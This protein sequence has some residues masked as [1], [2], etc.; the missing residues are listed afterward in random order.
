MYRIQT[1]NSTSLSSIGYDAE[2]HLLEAQFV[3]DQKTV[4]QY[5]DVPRDLWEEAQYVIANEGSIGQWFAAKIKKGG[6]SY[7]QV[8]L[9]DP[10]L[11]VVPVPGARVW[12]ADE[13]RELF[14]LEVHSLVRFWAGFPSEEVTITDR[15]NGLA[16]AILGIL[17]GHSSI[18]PGY[19]VAPIPHSRDQQYKSEMGQN[20]FPENHDTDV[21]GQIAGVLF[22]KYRLLRRATRSQ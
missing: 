18:S 15:L 8:A 12:T 16:E 5:P 1:P 13:V 4:Y 20:W 3:G 21:K 17:D 14:L 9:G 2:L 22:D 6:F 11:P 19:V 10:A 7:Y